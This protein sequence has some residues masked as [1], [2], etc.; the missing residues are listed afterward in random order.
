MHTFQINV[1]VHFFGVFYMLRKYFF[2][3]QEDHFYMQFCLVC[4]RMCSNE[5]ILA[6]NRLLT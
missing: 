5:H 1:L 6:P 3:H 2:H 4:A